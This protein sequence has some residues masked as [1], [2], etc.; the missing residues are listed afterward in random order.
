M[1]EEVN[2]FQRRKE[3]GYDVPNL[4]YEMWLASLK[5]DTGTPL[6]PAEAV[7]KQIGAITQQQD[8]TSFEE[9]ECQRKACLHPRA[10]QMVGCDLCP[11]W[12]H[13]LCVGIHLKNA[14]DV[15]FKCPSCC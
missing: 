3:E 1:P 5:S 13:C 12:Y 10:C 14:K 2:L 7:H 4:R 9:S 6:E 8:S 11:K 15:E